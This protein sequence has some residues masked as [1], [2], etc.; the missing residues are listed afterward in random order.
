MSSEEGKLFVGGLS[1]DTNEHNLEQ[2]FCKYEEVSDAEVVKDG[3][4]SRSR[5]FGFITFRNTYDAKD[6][7]HSMNGENLGGRQIRVDLAGM[8]SGGGRG[9]SG[10]GYGV[11][12]RDY[13]RGGGSYYNN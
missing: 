10:G 2:A 6:A 1:F 11:G 8:S 13:Y 5:G 9:G 4:T 12:S 3:E 7:L